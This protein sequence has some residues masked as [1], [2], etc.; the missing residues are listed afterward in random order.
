MK[1]KLILLT[2]ISAIII[3]AAGCSYIPGDSN[4]SYSEQA[5]DQTVGAEKIGIAECDELFEELARFAE[6]PEDNFATRAAKRAAANTLKDKIKQ[7][8]EQNKSD[9]AKVAKDCREYKAQFDMIR[10]EWNR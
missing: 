8:I 4:K 7:R 6:N 3:S 9:K 5:V 2:T 1:I 10:N